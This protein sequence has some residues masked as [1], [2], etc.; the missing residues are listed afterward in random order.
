MSFGRGGPFSGGPVQLSV[1][2]V[3]PWMRRLF[4]ILG[5]AFALQLIVGAASPEAEVA[6]IVWLGAST[7]FVVGRGAVWQLVTYALLHGGLFHLLTNFLGLWMFGA[8]VEWRLGPRRF[9]LLFVCCVAGGGLAHVLIGLFTGGN[10]PVIGAS[11]GVLGVVFAFILA[12]PDRTV[13]LLIP[14]IPMKART[15][16]WIV[17][18]I[19]LVGAIQANAAN[20]GVAHLA[21]LGGIATAWIFLRWQRRPPLPKIRFRRKPPLRVVRR[22]D[23]WF[24]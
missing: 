23:E 16:G 19:D 4:W 24:H 3:T 14:P 7:E 17:L 15:L 21:H 5:V 12:N 22:D 1:P 11:A 18:A 6:L 2:P 13:M 10:A 20:R 8:E 9:P